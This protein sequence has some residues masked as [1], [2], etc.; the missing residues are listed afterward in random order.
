MK[1][2][3]LP[4]KTDRLYQA[5]DFVTETAREYGGVKE[6]EKLELIAEEVFVNIASYAYKESQGSVRIEC[7][8]E[9]G[10][11]VVRFKDCGEPYNPLLRP[12][13]DIT[14]PAEERPVGGLGIYLVKENAD[15]IDYAYIDGENI[16]TVGMNLRGG[17][18]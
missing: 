7:S 8:A 1:E 10:L 18:K 13:P 4:A 12:A 6:P 11:F 3:V 15:Q 16:L 14:S 2:V 17:T 5:L 9:A